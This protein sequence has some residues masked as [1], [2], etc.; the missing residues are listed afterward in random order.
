[1]LQ[2]LLFIAI[3]ILIW[4]AVLEIWFPSIIQE[5]FQ[6]LVSV[7][8]SAMW[9]KWMP[10]RGDI[11]I[12]P[13]EEEN[14]Y[15]RDIHYFNG[16]ADV[17]R[18]GVNHD[19]CRMLSPK[20]DPSDLFFTCALGGTE[21]LS[22]LGYRTQSVKH[23]F[24]INRDDYMNNSDIAHCTG[25]CRILK[26]NQHTFEAK[27]NIATDT[28]FSTSLKIDLNPPK[29]IQTLLDFYQ[30][31]MFW[32]RFRDDIID[33]AQNLVIMKAG[34]INITEYPPNPEITEGISFDG[35]SQ[36]L[37]IGDNN[38]LEFGNAIPLKYLRAISIWVYFEEFTNNAH[39]F[40]FGNGPAT[41]NV[42]L[43][44]VGRGN[45]PIDEHSIGHGRRNPIK[46]QTVTPQQLM[47]SS[48][49]NV[50]EYICPAPQITGQTIHHN[51]HINGPAHT[52]D[53]IYEIWDGKQRKKDVQLRNAIQLKKWA[54]I[55]ITATSTDAFRPS[56]DFYINGIKIQTV[57]DGWLPLN[58]FTTHNY[59]GKSNWSSVTS[60]Y[61]NADELFKGKMFDFRGYGSIM[62]DT[63]IKHTYT[64]GCQMLGINN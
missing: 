53:L 31:I 50:N 2:G 30:G 57:D 17:Q 61:E 33:Y 51:T 43:G 9:A 11:G 7:G 18:I 4:V 25:Y 28:G 35:K 23:G 1:M 22:S 36:Y 10:R 52:A 54:H 58:N 39:I 19:F 56:L 62:S 29:Q 26:S 55:V 64:W 14:G 3:I 49:A 15:I 63:L 32:L 8:D 60:Q 46:E 5:G 21:G 20:S 37:Q 40:D 27:C 47:I 12:N 13:S 24:K 41:D 42:F 34:N 45:P 48:D 6:Q 38:E 59:I 44:I 16:Y